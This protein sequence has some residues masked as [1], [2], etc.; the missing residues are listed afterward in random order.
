M[1]FE[2]KRAAQIEQELVSLPVVG[3]LWVELREG[4]GNLWESPDK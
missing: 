3:D 2:L 4:P 1:V